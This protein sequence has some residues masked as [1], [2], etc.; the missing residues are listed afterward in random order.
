MALQAKYQAVLSLG[1][2]LG[3]RDG[4][5]KEENGVLKIGGTVETAYEKNL[6]WNKIKEIGGGTPSDI[7]ADIKVDTNDYYA[8][9][10]VA[11]GDTLGKI[12][13]HFYEEPKKYMQIFNANRDLLS[14]PNL[15]EVGQQLIIPF[16]V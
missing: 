12:A 6:I 9:Y 15:I 4:Y 10:T 7:E 1:E 11:K 16:E 3:A 14:D 13:G 8:R 2:K 5:V